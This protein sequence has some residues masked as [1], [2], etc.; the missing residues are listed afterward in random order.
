MGLPGCLFVHRSGTLSG[1]RV[2]E[3][4]ESGLVPSR[5]LAM[6]VERGALVHTQLALVKIIETTLTN[7]HEPER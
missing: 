7:E 2:D 4:D 6:G 3:R 1:A 5:W